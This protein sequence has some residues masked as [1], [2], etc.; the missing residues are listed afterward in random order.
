VVLVEVVRWLPFDGRF[1]AF[2]DVARVTD[3]RG[4]GVQLALYSVSLGV[5]VRAQLGFG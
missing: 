1:V 2:V 5:R 3:T 4:K